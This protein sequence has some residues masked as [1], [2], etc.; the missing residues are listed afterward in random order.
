MISSKPLYL[1]K[2]K[3]EAFGCGSDSYIIHIRKQSK[4]NKEAE[5]HYGDIFKY[6]KVTFFIL[7]PVSEKTFPIELLISN[8]DYT[9]LTIDQ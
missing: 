4:N 2:N 3:S 9:K 8:H 5:S 1:K 6:F 7:Y